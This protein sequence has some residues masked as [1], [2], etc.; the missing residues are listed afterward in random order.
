MLSEHGHELRRPWAAYLGDD[1]YE[2]RVKEQRVNY[3]ILY[4]FHRRWTTVLTNGFTKQGAA[5]PERE[6]SLAL[7]RKRAFEADPEQH[8]HREEPGS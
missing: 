5:V 7:R 2:L 1:V 6:I 4:F 8:T 3:R